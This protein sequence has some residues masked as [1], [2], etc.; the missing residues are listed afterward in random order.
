MSSSSQDSNSPTLKRLL[1]EFSKFERLNYKKDIVKF[2]TSK[3][4]EMP[5]LF[6]LS[7]ILLAV[8]TT[9]VLYYLNII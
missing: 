5:E 6:E 7:Q 3:K 9:Q 1:E 8:P 4:D 2:W